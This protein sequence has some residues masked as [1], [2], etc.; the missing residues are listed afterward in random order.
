VKGTRSML[1]IGSCEGQSLRGLAG[2]A[3]P[4]ARI[5]SI[6]IGTHEGVDVSG[7]L[8]LLMS[9]L[10]DGGF[11]AQNIIADS[12][13]QRASDWAQWDGPYDLVF[14]DGD[15]SYEGVRQDWLHYAGMGRVIAFHDIA[16]TGHG[17]KKLWDEIKAAGYRTRENIQSDMGIGLVF[18]NSRT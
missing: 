5:R 17:V 14:I 2:V 18:Q 10:R 7:L 16:H 3:A 8:S 12:H 13:S 11:D 4:G 1:E 9:E 15:H 6:D